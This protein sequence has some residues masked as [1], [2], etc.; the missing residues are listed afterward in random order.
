MFPKLLIHLDLSGSTLG[1]AYMGA[2]LQS[3][4]A[5]TS[6]KTLNQ[7]Y[8]NG[9]GNY[10]RAEILYRCSIPPFDNAREVL[11][12]LSATDVELKT[13][14]DINLNDVKLEIKNPDILQLCNIIPNEVLSLSKRGKGASSPSP[15]MHL[16]PCQPKIILSLVKQQ[17]QGCY[18]VL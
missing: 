5:H 8:F 18:Q 1:S 16:Y 13:K 6:R 12:P 2:F 14:N 4:S 9:I 7:K 15:K 17:K 11:E 10:L 3:K